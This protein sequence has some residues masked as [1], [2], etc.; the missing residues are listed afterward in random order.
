MSPRSDWAVILARGDS[1]RMGRPKGAVRLPDDPR[2]LL[3]R[4]AALYEG[5]GW[6]L[7]V[8]TTPALADV[9][10]A[11]WPGAAAARWI[12]GPRGEGT[13]ASVASALVVLGDQASHLW[14]HPVDLPHVWPQTLALLAALSARLPEAALTPH[15]RGR[16]GHPVVVPTAPLRDLAAQPLGGAFRDVLLAR[17]RGPARTG[18]TLAIVAVSDPGVVADHDGPV[19]QEAQP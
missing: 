13:A 1:R 14:L 19:G 12:I 7:A 8:V 5:G 18:P 4:V 2:P 9:Y 10:R 16:P 11:L 3:A 15:W 6:P 17:A